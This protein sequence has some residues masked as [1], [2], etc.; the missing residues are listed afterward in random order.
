MSK[1]SEKAQRNYQKYPGKMVSQAVKKHIP[2]LKIP[3]YYNSN[4]YVRTGNIITLKPDEEYFK[5]FS[6]DPNNPNIW[7]H[8][9][10]RQYLF[11][12]E[13]LW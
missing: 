4:S 9:L 1:P 3:A 7:Q 8:H 10:P 2:D 11:L 5:L 12:V 6:N 13:M